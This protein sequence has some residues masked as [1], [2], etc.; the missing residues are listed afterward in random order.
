MNLWTC[1]QFMQPVHT[2]P[3][4]AFQVANEVRADLIIPSHWGTITLTD[5]PPFEPPER[6]LDVAKN[7]GISDGRACIMKIGITRAV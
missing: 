6:H 4:E 7:N 1:R 5:E 2:N 3:E